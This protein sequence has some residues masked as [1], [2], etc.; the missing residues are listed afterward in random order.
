MKNDREEIKNYLKNLLQ[1]QGFESNFQEENYIK[2]LG[3][4]SLSTVNLLIKVE[5]EYS[6]QFDDKFLPKTM[7]EFIDAIINQIDNV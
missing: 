4:D 5:S 3:I 7:K 2:D 6:I 1:S